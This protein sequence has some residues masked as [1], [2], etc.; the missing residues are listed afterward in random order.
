[1]FYLRNYLLV[2][3]AIVLSGC[4]KPTITFS[5]PQIEP[6]QISTL[7]WDLSTEGATGAVSVEINDVDTGEIIGKW[8]A[9]GEYK[10]TY[11]ESKR[12]RAVVETREGGFKAEFPVVHVLVTGDPKV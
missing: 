12:Y 1:M 3:I 4:E 5:P 11:L 8:G 10:R 9:S 2:F 7:S 6:G